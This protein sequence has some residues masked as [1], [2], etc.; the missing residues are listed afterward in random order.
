MSNQFS[1]ELYKDIMHQL[2]RR[3][4]VF[5]DLS[6]N[7]LHAIRVRVANN[8]QIFPGQVPP[9][10]E[11]SVVLKT[12]EDFRV[13]LLTYRAFLKRIEEPEEQLPVSENPLRDIINILEKT[14]IYV[15]Q[16]SLPVVDTLLDYLARDNANERQ[17]QRILEQNHYLEFAD[18][19][20]N[21]GISDEHFL[22][23]LNKHYKMKL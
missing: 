1:P 16:L 2:K 5:T 21:A 15:G 22:L 12:L 13:N 7:D 9:S 4:V 3:H 11:A 8:Y 20:R 6:E 19:M 14:M 23:F 10:S 17:N 18:L